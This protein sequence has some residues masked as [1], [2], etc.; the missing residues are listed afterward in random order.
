VAALCVLLSAPPAHSD[1]PPADPSP[2][3]YPAQKISLRYSHRVHIQQEG[4]RC[5]DCH[6]AAPDSWKSSDLLLPKEERCADCH[7]EVKDKERCSY[8]HPGGE[9]RQPFE[10][11]PAFLRFD[12]RGHLRNGVR[13]VDC[14]P[15]VAQ[16]ELATVDDLPRMADCV[17]CHRQRRASTECAACHPTG[18][19][20]RVAVRLGGAILKPASHRPGWDRAHRADAEAGAAD[21]LACHAESECLACHDGSER[22]GIHPG[23][24]IVLHPQAALANETRCMSCHRLERFCQDCHQR[25]GVRFGALPSGSFHPA[26]WA[27]P[28]AGADH[29]SHVARRNIEAC[30]SCHAEP[31]CVACHGN[32]SGPRVNPHPPGFDGAAIFR[33]NRSACLKCHAPSDPRLP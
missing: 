21:C 6:G 19:E 7:A 2:A 25:T 9:T 26:G 8:C 28:T 30:A 10:F 11:P 3:V 17:A 5:L 32:V 13:C 12:H 14:H 29:H 16:R 15:Q 27:A 1:A 22:P 31:E 4:M 23:D 18:P 20:G 24:W 33:R